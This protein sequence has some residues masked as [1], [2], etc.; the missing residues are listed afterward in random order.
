MYYYHD[1]LAGLE[2][3]TLQYLQFQNDV[4]KSIE[5][6]PHFS[7]VMFR[8]H[9]KGYID[10]AKQLDVRINID[11]AL[12][13]PVK[14]IRSVRF[15]KPIKSAKYNYAACRSYHNL[16]KQ[17]RDCQLAIMHLFLHNG[18]TALYPLT[19]LSSSTLFLVVL[20]AGTARTSYDLFPDV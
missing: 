9:V 2:Q 13:P 5:F 14:M 11:N 16:A 7:S 20:A 10:C 12:L 6:K 18:R 17:S 1:A 3:S 8:F 15:F 4:V 19:S